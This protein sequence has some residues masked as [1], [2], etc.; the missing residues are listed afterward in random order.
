MGSTAWRLSGNAF[1]SHWFLWLIME[2]EPR[3]P[4]LLTVSSCPCW[5]LPDL[6]PCQQGYYS[7]K[8][9]HHSV[10]ESHISVHTSP[11]TH[12]NTHTQAGVSSTYQSLSSILS[13][14]ESVC[15]CACT[16]VHARSVERTE[17]EFKWVS[18]MCVGKCVFL[19]TCVCKAADTSTSE[20]I[21]M[22]YTLKHQ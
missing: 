11:L 2:V 6:R 15:V 16:C 17:C 19:T 8:P 18:L 21:W 1:L 5:R 3:P 4:K 9:P 10:S 22:L 7:S 20:H 13:E 14:R 12:L